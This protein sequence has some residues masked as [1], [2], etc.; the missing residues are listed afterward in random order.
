MVAH[1]YYWPGLFKDVRDY[2]G[3]NRTNDMA[4]HQ[5]YWPGLFKDVR[6]YLGLNTTNDMVARKYYW[7][8]PFKDVRDYVS[9]TP[10]HWTHSTRA[11]F[12]HDIFN[13]PT[14]TSYGLPFLSLLQPYC[15]LCLYLNISF[16]L[17]SKF[18][19]MEHYSTSLPQKTV[20]PS[21]LLRWRSNIV[22]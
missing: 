9:V 1:Q 4:A 18:L 3:L 11:Y 8:G 19:L 10:G 21:L 20:L 22:I 7:P 5:Y 13:F 2:L 16:F 15:S 12:P 6:D 14:S 17:C